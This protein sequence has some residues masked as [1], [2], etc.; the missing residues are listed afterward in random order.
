MMHAASELREF[1]RFLS[2]KL[3]NGGAELLPEEA[4][5]EWRQL[6]PELSEEA[7]DEGSSLAANEHRF[8][9]LSRQW[10]TETKF[11]SNISSKSVHPAY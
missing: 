8:N 3:E 6:H 7:L 5:D 1:H 2:A 10:K 11:L 9:E 4:L